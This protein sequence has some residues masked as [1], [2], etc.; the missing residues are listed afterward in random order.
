MRQWTPKDICNEILYQCIQLDKFHCWNRDCRCMDSVQDKMTAYYKYLRLVIIYSQWT[1][2]CW[3]DNFLRLF[4]QVKT[5]ISYTCYTYTRYF[6]GR[7]VVDLF[8]MAP[9]LFSHGLFDFSRFNTVQIT[10]LLYVSIHSCIGTTTYKIGH[11]I[12]MV[13]QCHPIHFRIEIFSF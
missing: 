9:R 12:D 4:D 3:S 11:Q 13:G 8:G 5:R 6:F 7:V 10:P 1:Q 2:S